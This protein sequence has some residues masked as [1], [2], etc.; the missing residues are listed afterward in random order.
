MKVKKKLNRLLRIL[1]YSIMLVGLLTT[2]AFAEGATIIDVSNSEELSNAINRINADTDTNNEY[3]INLTADIETNG[4]GVQ[5]PCHVT[6]LGNGHTLTVR[7]Y[8]SITINA[9][10]S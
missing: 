9:G 2:T 5:S 8:E 7:Q 1:L 10:H 3:V 4:F 6:I